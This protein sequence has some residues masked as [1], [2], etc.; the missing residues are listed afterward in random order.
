[1]KDYI[2]A[3]ERVSQPAQSYWLLDLVFLVGLFGFVFFCLIILS[4]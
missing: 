2:T 4:N 3:N 1:M